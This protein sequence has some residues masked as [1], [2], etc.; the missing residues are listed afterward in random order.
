MVLRRKEYAWITRPR[1]LRRTGIAV[2]RALP[3]APARR[4]VVKGVRSAR[5]ALGLTRRHRAF[6]R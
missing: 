4:A 5:G 1:G 2:V 6:R 3:F